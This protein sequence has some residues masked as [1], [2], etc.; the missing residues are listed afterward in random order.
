MIPSNNLFAVAKAYNLTSPPAKSKEEYLIQGKA[1]LDDV[2]PYAEAVLP[3]FNK[4]RKKTTSA[5]FQFDAL[6]SVAYDIGLDLFF[7]SELPSVTENKLSKRELLK[8]FTGIPC[9]ENILRSEIEEQMRKYRMPILS[10]REIEF[11]LFIGSPIF[12]IGRCIDP[13]GSGEIVYSVSVM[14]PLIQFL[15]QTR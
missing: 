9:F 4:T 7:D 2:K 1:F 10:R 11:R 8:I 13:S 5:Q 14:H 12:S 15:C 3:L 6:T